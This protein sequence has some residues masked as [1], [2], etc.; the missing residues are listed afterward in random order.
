MG[1]MEGHKEEPKKITNGYITLLKYIDF[2]WDGR[3]QREAKE[4]NKW[5]AVYM[6]QQQRLIVSYKEEHMPGRLWSHHGT[7]DKDP[8]LGHWVGSESTK[9]KMQT[10]RNKQRLKVLNDNN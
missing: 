10:E 2:A 7:C 3:A 6:Y 5:M 4:N 8:R 9:Q 1:W